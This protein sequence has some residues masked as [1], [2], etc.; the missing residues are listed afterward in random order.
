M[1]SL[2]QTWD[3]SNETER[4]NDSSIKESFSENLMDEN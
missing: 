4:E 1:T 3:L 2:T